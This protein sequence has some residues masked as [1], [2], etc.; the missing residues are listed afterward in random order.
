MHGETRIAV[1]DPYLDRS[2]RQ[3]GADLA[4]GVGDGTEQRQSGCGLDGDAQSLGDV[5][6]VFIGQ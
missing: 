6:G 2:G 1:D 5:L 4:G 3:L